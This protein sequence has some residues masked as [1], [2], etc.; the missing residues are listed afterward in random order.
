MRYGS[1]L[2]RRAIAAMMPPL[3]S[4]LLD[5]F[6]EYEPLEAGERPALIQAVTLCKDEQATL[7]LGKID[8]MRSAVRW[9]GYVAEQGVKFRG[10]DAPHINQLSYNR[11]IV[12]DHYWRKELGQRVSEGLSAAKQ[13][14][15]RL[16]G[17]RGHLDG[18][19]LGPA[20]SAEA[21]RANARD[22]D[23]ATWAV[24]KEVRYRGVT[25]LTGIAK[26]LNQMGHTA[27]RGGEW[28]PAQVRLVIKRF[29]D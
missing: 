16:G 25:S 12:S 2:Q 21:R 3:R 11:L 22:R 24:I 14:G 7:L 8:R 29:E 28:S 23:A 6:I 18:L 15:L 9:L 5:E 4:K 13:R 10:V 19:K 27:P 20:A 26:R 17:Y 1:G